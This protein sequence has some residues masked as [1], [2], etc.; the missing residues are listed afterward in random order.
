MLQMCG[1]FAEF[2]HEIIGERVKAG[3]ARAR[4]GGIKL[5]RHGIRPLTTFRNTIRIFSV[6]NAAVVIGHKP[7]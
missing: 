3:L 4:D 7:D 5:G 6:G 1:V 2:E